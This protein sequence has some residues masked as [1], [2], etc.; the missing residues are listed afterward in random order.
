MTEW[1]SVTEAAELTSYNVAY[2]RELIRT[3]K[4]TARKFATVWQVDRASLFVYVKAAE[5]S[6][7]KRRGAKKRS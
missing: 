2:L 7:D 3:G 1:I 4:V 6:D 5:K